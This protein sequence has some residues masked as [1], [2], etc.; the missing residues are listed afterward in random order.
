MLY[1]NALVALDTGAFRELPDS[2]L[3][4][5]RLSYEHQDLVRALDE[6]IQTP[7][8]RKELAA[9]ARAY[10]EKTYRPEL[11]AQRVRELLQVTSRAAPLLRLADRVSRL[12]AEIGCPPGSTAIHRVI[13]CMDDAFLGEPA[14]DEWSGWF[15]E[16][17]SEPRS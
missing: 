13:Q 15:R 4:R 14:I 10:A 1:D 8:R 16:N 11:Y 2:A 9:R 17:R 7:A 3:A 5:V 6:L 12:F